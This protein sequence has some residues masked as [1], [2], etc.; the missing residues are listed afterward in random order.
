MIIE[1]S[2]RGPGKMLITK[3]GFLISGLI[4][5]R[6]RHTAGDSVRKRRS[7]VKREGYGERARERERERATATDRERLDRVLTERDIDY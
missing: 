6:P 5:K 2:Q 3:D 1:P 7:G 4:H